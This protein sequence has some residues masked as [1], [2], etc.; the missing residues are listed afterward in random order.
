MSSDPVR[1][2]VL[3]QG[4]IVLLIGFFAGF[5]IVSGGPHA[6]GWL[7]THLTVMITAVFMILIGLVWDDL[8]LSKGQRRVLHFAL[9]L[10]GYWG[11]VAGAFATVFAIPGPV[12]GHGVQPSGWP[13]TVFFGVFLPVLTILPFVF[14]GLTLYG[15]RGAPTS[16]EDP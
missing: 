6:R 11:F 13:A 5:G 14:V 7:G 1:R 10:D 4:F 16:R 9:V 3:R 15:L 8:V 12:S 2:S